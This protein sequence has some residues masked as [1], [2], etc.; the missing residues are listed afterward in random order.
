MVKLDL[1]THS[2]LSHDGGLG[3]RDYERIISS[4]KLGC[5]AITDHNEIAFALRMQE[6][7][8]SAIIVGEEIMTS[9]GEII[10][11]FLREKIEP[12]MNARE[13]VA[14]I[15]RQKGIA[16]IPH[17]FETVR[18]GVTAQ[19]LETI[20]ESVDI[21]ET[22]NGRGIFMHHVTPGVGEPQAR[23]DPRGQGMV[24]A[25]SSDAHCAAGIG[26][27]YSIVESDVSRENLVAQLRKGKLHTKYAPMYSLLCPKVNVLKKL[28]VSPSR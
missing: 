2:I 6:K 10:G 3:E 17:P 16:Y 22:F 7:L 4:G 20:R 18:S 11:L 28:F 15:K 1:H 8:G 27:S 26:T 14:E 25:A 19:A 21:I 24:A 12:G 13:T 5:M 23:T 9:E